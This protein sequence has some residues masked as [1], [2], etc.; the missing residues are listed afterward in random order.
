VNITWGAIV[1]I[2]LTDRT[3]LFRTRGEA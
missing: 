3:D 2:S 1:A